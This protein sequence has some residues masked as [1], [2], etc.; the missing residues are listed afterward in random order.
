VFASAAADDEN[1]HNFQ[2]VNF[3]NFR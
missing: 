3:I 2:K 1:F